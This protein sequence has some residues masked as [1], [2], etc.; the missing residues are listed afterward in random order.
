MPDLN[1]LTDRDR[2]LVGVALE[3]LADG[4]KDAAKKAREVE[5]DA[6]AVTM[7]GR[8]LYVLETLA[9]LFHVQEELLGNEGEAGARAGLANVLFD[10]LNDAG[11]TGELAHAADKVASRVAVLCVAV[12]G[13]AFAEGERARRQ[14]PSVAIVRSLNAFRTGE[15]D[16]TSRLP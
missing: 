14:L 1:E 3:F 12:Y 5:E 13:R 6:S 10:L 11:L 16:A 9:P 8:K 7:D 4:Y 2:K 15:V